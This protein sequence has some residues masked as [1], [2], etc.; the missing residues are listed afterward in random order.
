[1]TAFGNAVIIANDLL[2]GGDENVVVKFLFQNIK[3]SQRRSKTISALFVY[4]H[5]QPM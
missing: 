2:P 5:F 1:M 3:F 4:L